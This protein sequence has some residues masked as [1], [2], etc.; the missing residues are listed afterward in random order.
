MVK[1][2]LETALM[3][4]MEVDTVVST[5]DGAGVGAEEGEMGVCI[6]SPSD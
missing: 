4:G 2:G 1:E 5:A 6:L 3:Q